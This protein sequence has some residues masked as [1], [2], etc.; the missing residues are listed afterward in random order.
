MCWALG[1]IYNMYIYCYIAMYICGFTCMLQW[2]PMC[3]I[4][5]FHKVLINSKLAAYKPHSNTWI[6]LE[7]FVEITQIDKYYIPMVLQMVRMTQ[8]G[9]RLNL[10]F[11][12]QNLLRCILSYLYDKS[13]K[14]QDIFEKLKK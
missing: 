1:R 5:K 14:K 12:V 7:K 8:I 2:V 10:N 6:Q 4:G 3:R 13:F 9:M 11:V